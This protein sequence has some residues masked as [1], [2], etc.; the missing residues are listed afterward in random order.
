MEMLKGRTK[1]LTEF[2]GGCGAGRLYCG[3]EPNGDIEPCVF[4]PIKLGNIREQS[5]V[6]IWRNSPVLKQI[7][8]RDA[9]EGCGECEY[10]Y[11][12]GG[13]RARAYAYFNNLQGPDPACSINEKYWKKVRNQI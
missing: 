7:R 5:L 4:I 10:K 8:S 12:C 11:I 13:C 9:F 6:D 2:I 1:S 3:M